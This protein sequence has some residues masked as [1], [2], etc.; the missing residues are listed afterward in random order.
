M[1]FSQKDNVQ[2]YRGGA[3]H[4]EMSF[5]RYPAGC[6][7]IEYQECGLPEETR[8]YA[9]LKTCVQFGVSCI[10]VTLWSPQRAHVTV[11]PA[12]KDDSDNACRRSFYMFIKYG[13]VGLELNQIRQP[14]SSHGH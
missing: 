3:P 14:A 1:N 11:F 9:G 13:S 4:I 6:D 10:S 7:Y 5:P 8:N 12:E 2:Q